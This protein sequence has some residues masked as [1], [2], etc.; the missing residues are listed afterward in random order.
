MNV[1]FGMTA[2]D[3][4]KYRAGFPD[5]FFERVFSDG[6]AKIGDALVDLGTGT[7]TLARG[8]AARGCNVTGVDISV[9]LLEQA[10]DLCLQEDVEVEFRFAKAE[11]TGLPDS[12]FDVVSAGQCWH[13]FDRPRA[14]GEA[15]RLLK[16]RGRVLIAHFDWL[17]LEGNVA[18]GTEK[19]VQKYNPAWYERFGN[20]TGIHPDW[21]RDLGEA[22]FENI[23]SFSFDLDVPYT[24][25]AWRGRIRASSGV[26]A[27]LSDED[28]GR[29]DSELKSLLERFEQAAAGTHAILKI[30]HRV[31]AVHAGKG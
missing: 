19:L 9:P 29:F 31:F 21:F 24:P 27:S 2:D 6:I 11:E 7:G 28:I 23:L 22:G 26:G 30:P 1:N 25:D 16:P 17:P 13:W 10:K 14:A 20:K 5:E 15:M 3:Y 12:S 18:D 4:A 8:F